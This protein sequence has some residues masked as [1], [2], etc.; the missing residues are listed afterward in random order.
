MKNKKRR[1]QH[2]L[3]RI[4][5]LWDYAYSDKETRGYSTGT[6]STIIKNE[7]GQYIVITFDEVMDRWKAPDLVYQI[8]TF[9]CK[10]HPAKVCLP[11]IAGWD[12]LRDALFQAA[13]KYGVPN[14][15][16]RVY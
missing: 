4:F 3:G 6:T 14:M 13:Q 7:K 5:Q 12:F 15:M 11:K 1:T 2:G 9:Y 16:T 8:V 10:W